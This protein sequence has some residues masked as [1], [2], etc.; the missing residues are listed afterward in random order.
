MK[1]KM[2]AKDTL[3]EL[4]VG[5]MILLFV[6]VPFFDMLGSKTNDIPADSPWNSAENPDIVTGVDLLKP[7]WWLGVAVIIVFVGV[8][9]WALFGTDGG[10]GM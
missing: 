10:G 6:V 5:A 8:G 7:M 9:A 1:T 3:I 4:M 2:E